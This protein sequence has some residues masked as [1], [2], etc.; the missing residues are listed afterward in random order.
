MAGHLRAAGDEALWMLLIQDIIKETAAI[1]LLEDFY[2]P[3][4]LQQ[5]LERLREL[6]SVYPKHPLTKGLLAGMDARTNGL[7]AAAAKIVARWHQRDEAAGPANQP[8]TVKTLPAVDCCDH[9]YPP[10]MGAALANLMR[11]L[12]ACGDFFEGAYLHG[13][14]ATLD[15]IPGASDLDLVYVLNETTS[16]DDGRLLALRSLLKKTTASFYAVDPF[17]HHGPYI[18]TPKIKTN[19]VESYLPL[20]VW[21]RSRPLMGSDR[22]QLAI[23]KSEFHR[24]LW[25]RR[26]VQ[27]YRRC[28]IERK[29]TNSVFDAKLIVSM[30]SLLP[31]IAYAWVTGEYAD[32]PAAISWLKRTFPEAF[33]L[34]WLDR[35]T[36]IRSGNLFQ[37]DRNATAS[38]HLPDTTSKVGDELQYL[39]TDVPYWGPAEICDHILGVRIAEKPYRHF[40]KLSNWPRPIGSD[41][42]HKLTEK[43]GRRAGAIASV[44]RV[45]MTGNVRTPGISDLDFLLV[46]DDFLPQSTAKELNGLYD[47]FDDEERAVIMHDPVAIVPECLLPDLPLLFPVSVTSSLSGE[48]PVFN[49]LPPDDRR[50]LALIHLTDLAIAMNGRL[51]KEMLLRKEMD[52]RLVLN[53]LGGLK[54]S[55]RLFEEAG[56]HAGPF[57]PL[58]EHI[59]VLR[60]Q[61]FEIVAWDRLPGFLNLGVDLVG[62]LNHGIHT[63]W[64]GQAAHSRPF[65]FRTPSTGV[66]FVTQEETFGC[67][68]E[69]GEIVMHLP[70]VFA[71]SLRHYGAQKG[72]LS[73]F[74]TRNLA[75]PAMA[76]NGPMGRLLTSRAKCL[77]DHFAYLLSNGLRRGFFAPF[78]FGWQLWKDESRHVVK[79][80]ASGERGVDGPENVLTESART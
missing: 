42:Y 15:F 44:T 75:V 39:L 12:E 63:L 24:Q 70:S 23:E 48:R 45:L 37:S 31:A 38:R 22:I 21:R 25:F 35:I 51:F 33:I 5:A 46:T 6:L 41:V 40:R 9:A 8:Q 10:C 13:S 65:S 68:I 59:E 57:E 62:K 28:C 27:Y 47:C 14:L 72:P 36:C 53:Q 64:K 1:V 71:C 2:G 60:N 54:Y 73:A 77:N 67:H 26:S 19:Y 78:H 29:R 16:K 79:D 61:W 69:N 30:A 43:I 11:I 32:K 66:D 17:Q 52:V 74:I 4:A 50:C 76:L 58:L 20:A 49:D 34:D 3:K 7:L 80:W 56:G 18:I 55:I